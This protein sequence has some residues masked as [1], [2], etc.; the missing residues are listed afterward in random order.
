[1][2]GIFSLVRE[3]Y[4]L[5]SGV[6]P[7][8]SLF[9]SLVFISYIISA[10]ILWA[11]EHNERGKLEKRDT[12]TRPRLILETTTYTG[13]EWIFYEDALL[14]FVHNIGQRPASFVT[15]DPI[16]SQSGKYTLK[17]TGPAIVNSGQRPPLTF[18]VIE[19]DP[20]LPDPASEPARGY[21]EML[22]E[23]FKDN[24]HKTHQ[25]LFNI[26]MRCR[27][28]KSKVVDT[29]KLQW[30]RKSQKLAVLPD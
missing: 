12:E 23:F 19:N 24:P 2:S 6:V 28:A 15:I 30:D 27:D 22:Y 16:Q 18:E 9:W 13:P 25:T 26:V 20:S 10:A 3:L 29:M 5:Y 8:K 21:P 7:P 4:A 1:M 14:F 17:L 11:I